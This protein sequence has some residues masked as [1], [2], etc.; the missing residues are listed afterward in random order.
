VGAGAGAF[1]SCVA[2]SA[3]GAAFA[4]EGF[5]DGVDEAGAAVRVAKL[6]DAEATGVG[7][8]GCAGATWAE[9]AGDDVKLTATPIPP[10]MHRQPAMP[11]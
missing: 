7:E 1:T 4:V 2:T 10:A 5:T 8:A 6:V 9:A 3:P 11:R